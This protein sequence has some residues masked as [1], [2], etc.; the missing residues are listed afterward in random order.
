VL[1]SFLSYLTGQSVA[2]VGKYCSMDDD[3]LGQLTSIGAS[4][5]GKSTVVQL[6]ERFYDV[7]E[8][9]LVKILLF[10]CRKAKTDVTCM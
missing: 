5:C 9:Q 4:G 7:N 1:T 2:L 3:P 6:I 10:P 8:G